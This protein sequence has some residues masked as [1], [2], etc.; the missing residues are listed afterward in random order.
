MMPIYFDHN[1]TTPLDPRVLE[2]MLPYLTGP[3]G[4]PSSVH[5]YGRAARDAVEAA[6]VQVAALAGAQPAEVVWT[7]GGT[8]SNNLALQGA[9]AVAA[10]PSRILYGGTEHPAVLETAESLRRHGWQVETIAIDGQ[11]LVDWPA[12]E[13]QLAR[14]PLCIAALM[15]ANNE[16]GV[17]QDV[18]RA[19]AAVHA[20][21][22]LLLAD[23]VQAAGK[24]LLDF[25]A[26][27][28]DLMSLSSHKLYGPKGVGALLVKAGVELA[29]LLHGGGQERGLRGGTE[30]VAAIV[31]FGAAAELA[32]QE[33]Q[34]RDAH[35][36]ALRERLI[37][38]LHVLPGVSI[39]GEQSPRLSN[40][41]QFGLKGWEGEALLMA[42]DRKGI[43][44]SSGSAC[45]SG[46]GEPSHVLLG[47]GLPR[48]VAYGAIRVSLG[49]G[50]T[51]AEI[52]RFLAVLDELRAAALA[53]A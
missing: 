15:V 31:G 4:N 33:L 43:A 42:L 7:S 19:A 41:V 39:F 35:L 46:K 51:A 16:T 53:A 2:A 27:G 8:E 49:Q 28:A 24:L 12:F 21:R 3:Y 29:P 22:A 44:V 18:P 30:N 14:G 1:A 48:D 45:S 38:G 34:A 11:G 10:R 9:A 40:T 52:D 47:M 32:Q 13:A 50:N 6:R 5:R 25:T 37:A 17:I 36:L 20:A 23:A 26:S